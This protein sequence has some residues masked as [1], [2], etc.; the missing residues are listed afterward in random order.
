MQLNNQTPTGWA[1]QKIDQTKGMRSDFFAENGGKGKRNNPWI[2][3]EVAGKIAGVATEGIG[4]IGA[5]IDF[6]NDIKGSI[7]EYRDMSFQS[8][9]TMINGVPSYEGVSKLNSQWSS[10]DTKNAGKG[11][12]VQGAMTG[13]KAGAAIGGAFT[14]VG[15]LI[16]AGAGAIAGLVGGLFGKNKAEDEAQKAKERG[17]QQFLAKQGEYNE[18]VESYYDT[19]DAK[20]QES[21]GER[22]QA[23]RRY[24]VA[25]YNDPFRSIV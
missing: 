21:Q 11:L 7:N 2:N 5:G 18:D 15:G 23:S 1:N 24:G 3:S 17:R 19:V 22:N 16:G 20:R 6:A 8:G 4:A 10:I 9:D 12:G 13:A 14:P 25:Q